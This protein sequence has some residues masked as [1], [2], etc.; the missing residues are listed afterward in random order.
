[1]GL[2]DTE[3]WN[4]EITKYDL[5]CPHYGAEK[6]DMSTYI[7]NLV[8]ACFLLIQSLCNLFTFIFSW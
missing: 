8:N 5:L 2:H 1:M 6:R 4:E 3:C 7:R